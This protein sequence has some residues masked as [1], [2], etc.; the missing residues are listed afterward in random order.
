VS[1]VPVATRLTK[2]EYQELLRRCEK[3]GEL[4][5]EFVGRLIR[6]E[7]RHRDGQGTRER[8]RREQD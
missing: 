7:L 2:A 3:T 5:T 8:L 4:V 1:N 6:H